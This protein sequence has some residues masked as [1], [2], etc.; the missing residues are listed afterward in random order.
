M[1][2]NYFMMSNVSHTSVSEIFLKFKKQTVVGKDGKKF[3]LV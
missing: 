2:P 1:D 3:L